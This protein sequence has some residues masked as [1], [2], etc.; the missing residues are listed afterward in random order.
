M[1]LMGR[2]TPDLPPDVLFSDIELHVLRAYEKKRLKPPATLRGAVRLVAR[3][4]G[5]LRPAGDAELQILCEGFV[6][7]EFALDSR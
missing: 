7:W 4:G 6:I 2:E 5:I 1:T 3:R